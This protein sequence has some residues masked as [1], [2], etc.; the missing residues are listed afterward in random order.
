MSSGSPLFL[1]NIAQRIRRLLTPPQQRQAVG[2]MGLS[3]LGNLA[4]VIGLASVVPYVLMIVDQDFFENNPYVR[5]LYEVLPVTS[6][7][8]FLLVVLIGILLLFIGKNA[9]ALGIDYRQARFAYDMATDFSRRQARYF[10]SRDWPFHQQFSGHRV[11]NEAKTIPF[12]FGTNVLLRGI[13]VVSDGLLGL[14]ILGVVLAVDPWI[15][16]ALA[17][18]LVPLVITGYQ[19]MKEQI[20]Q[21]GTQRN[22]L[23]P[24]ASNAAIQM[25]QAYP[26]IKLYQKEPH[27]LDQFVS[28]QRQLHN[29]QTWITTY[30]AFTR[31]FMEVNAL[32]GIL[33]IAAYTALMGYS[34]Q[35]LFLFL[36]VYATAS[37]KL[38]PSI[39][40]VFD[41]ILT[42]R[43]T[44]YALDNLE[45]HLTA[46]QEQAD[47]QA[48]VRPIPFRDAIQL[49]DIRF[50][51]PEHTK[52][53]LDG[54]S[55]TIRK[56]EAVGIMGPSGE[57]KSTL[58]YVLMQLLQ[59]DSGS[60]T[61]DGQALT[62]ERQRAWQQHL[63][64]VWHQNFV[65]SGTLREN[66]AF[67]E[68]P[69]SVDENCLHQVVQEASLQELVRSWPG[70]LD[71]P[72]AES[73]HSLSEGQR[74]RIALARALYRNAS[75]LLLDEA[76]NALDAHTEALIR[77]TLADQKAAGKTLIMVSHRSQSLGI[78]DAVYEMQNGQLLTPADNQGPDERISNGALT[79][80]NHNL[81]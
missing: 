7:V 34:G 9:I 25:N 16:V 40:R 59:P 61:V 56:G 73:G 24:Y 62:P 57:G 32:M 21:L 37:Y 4:E 2:V 33:I 42:I 76:T 12:M 36:S 27:F 11:L 48:P 54:V 60:I 18:I 35:Q 64:L 67:A 53:T 77:Q 52:P 68:H 78:C 47:W 6:K 10:L 65:M 3:F 74:Q 8:S 72:I 71:A 38:M 29:I 41:S 15:G 26:V 45:A 1:I 50:T 46:E 17:V 69:E 79:L 44:T 39:S 63:G 51:Y 5:A 23:Q 13:G 14:L 49:Q 43:S 20:K 80:S 30:S 66:I 81:S 55:L 75:V 58:L 19:R 22:A 70:G 31:K 28:Y